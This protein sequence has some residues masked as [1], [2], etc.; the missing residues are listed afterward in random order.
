MEW[1]SVDLS[2]CPV[3]RA[4]EVVGR[5]WTLI[6]LR[7]ALNGVRRFEDFQ[8]H[9]GVSPSVLASRLTD[10]VGDGLLE[11]VPYREDRTRGRNEY[12]PTAKAWALYPV[13]VGLM[14][15]GEQYLPGPR[16]PSVRLIDQ[17][18]GKPVIAAVVPDDTPTCSP[19]DIQVLTTT[20][21]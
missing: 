2:D 20:R 12:Q 7:E 17:A 10:M 5:R 16:A 1:T 18:T 19:A 15:W 6:V 13:L 14:Q 3:I 8:Q 11:R 9:L 21:A 4:L